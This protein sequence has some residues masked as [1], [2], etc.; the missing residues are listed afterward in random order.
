M[1]SCFL[2]L[3]MA[4]VSWAPVQ[5]GRTARPR[6]PAALLVGRT[7]CVACASDGDEYNEFDVANATLLSRRRKKKPK[8]NRDALLYEVVEATLPKGP[9]SR[10]FSLAP[11]LPI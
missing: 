2:G 10:L 8:D 4:S 5:V 11:S 9:P 3:L 1:V 6:A 7:G